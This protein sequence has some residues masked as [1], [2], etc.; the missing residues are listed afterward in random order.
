MQE[1][2]GHAKLL[3]RDGF[4][5]GGALKRSGPRFYM[6]FYIKNADFPASPPLFV[7]RPFGVGT[8]FLSLRV[9]AR[10]PACAPSFENRA[11]R[12]SLS[13]REGLIGVVQF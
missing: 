13:R 2:I 3:L 11:I 10:Q 6:K 5:R 1:R 8:S 12:P 4:K 9:I 7:N